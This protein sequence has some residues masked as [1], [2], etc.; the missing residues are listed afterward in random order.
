L[1]AV[2]S[3]ADDNDDFDGGLLDKLS[4]DGMMT[5]GKDNVTSRLD[6]YAPGS[7]A[8]VPPSCATYRPSD[9][10]DATLGGRPFA[11]QGH[12]HHG[13]SHRHDDSSKVKVKSE[14]SDVADKGQQQ[15]AN[16]NDK[17]PTAGDAAIMAPSA[18]IRLSV[19]SSSHDSKEADSKSCS[20]DK[21]DTSECCRDD[22]ASSTGGTKEDGG[23]GGTQGGSG[24]S[25]GAPQ[26]GCT[27]RRGPRTTI[28]A[29]Q[30]ETLKAAFNATP[31][32]TRHIREQLA[33]ET[34]LNMRVIQVRQSINVVCVPV[35]DGV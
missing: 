28:K 12:G 6:L 29:K 30:L 2:A 13:H 3:E 32:P 7:D 16:V 10:A 8:Q 35:L 5:P 31:K 21:S 22:A 24:S 11:S 26:P 1:T 17:Q 15:F 33:Q 20:D 27:K 18:L 9:N 23:S 34:G 4:G 25:A 14:H 19:T